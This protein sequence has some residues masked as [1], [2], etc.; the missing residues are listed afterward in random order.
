[1]GGSR[2]SPKA[3]EP[4]KQLAM[5]HENTVPKGIDAPAPNLDAWIAALIAGGHCNTNIYMAPTKHVP[6]QTNGES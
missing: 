5:K 6:I 4:S 1:M 3:V 2:A